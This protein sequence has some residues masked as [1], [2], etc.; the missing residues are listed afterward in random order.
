MET[1]EALAGHTLVSMG[2][3]SGPGKMTRLYPALFQRA[4]ASN[5]CSASLSRRLRLPG[6]RAPAKKSLRVRVCEFWACHP[7]IWMALHNCSQRS[8]S[9]RSLSVPTRR[10][11]S[12]SLNAPACQ[13]RVAKV[14]LKTSGMSPG[15]GGSWKNPAPS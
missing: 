13:I 11:G 2:R 4:S 15:G 9:N 1:G 8:A 14:P 6:R 12:C 3:M 10:Q 7:K 5:C